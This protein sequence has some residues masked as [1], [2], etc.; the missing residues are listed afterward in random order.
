MQIMTVNLQL[1]IPADVLSSMLKAANSGM[2][3]SIDGILI[4]KGDVDVNKN[5]AKLTGS[6]GS[7]GSV[8][9]PMQQLMRD[10]RM[11]AFFPRKTAAITYHYANPKQE[12][13][14]KGKKKNAKTK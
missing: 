6:V 10:T 4:Q 14:C 8:Y 12:N 11:D 1:Q 2:P 3:I 9:V 5:T 7:V 13:P